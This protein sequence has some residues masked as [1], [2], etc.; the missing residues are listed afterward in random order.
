MKTKTIL[1]LAL[2]L[3]AGQRAWAQASESL[4]FVTKSN[5]I[6]LYTFNWLKGRPT[7]I[8]AVRLTGDDAPSDNVWYDLQGRCLSSTP[9]KSGVYIKGGKK[10]VFK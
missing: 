10:V 1:L 2:L 8:H 9:T 5:W 3:T 4:T 6:S 7:S